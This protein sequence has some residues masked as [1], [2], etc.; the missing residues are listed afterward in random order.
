V[1]NINEKESNT[2]SEMPCQLK[3]EDF[4]SFESFQTF[5]TVFWAFFFD[6]L[7]FSVL[8]DRFERLELSDRALSQ[9]VR[10][11]HVPVTK[12]SKVLESSIGPPKR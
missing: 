7:L 12:L 2:R 3:R 10:L 9:Q 6:I 8:L 5:S 11:F 4:K 1:E